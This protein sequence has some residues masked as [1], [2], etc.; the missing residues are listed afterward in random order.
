MNEITNTHLLFNKQ[1][2]LAVKGY[3]RHMN[4]VDNS[5]S[6]RIPYARLREWDFYQIVFDDRYVLQLIM[7]HVGAVASVGAGLLDTVTGD[8]Y[9]CGDRS[10]SLRFFDRP[11]SK[12]PEAPGMVHF[13][14]K[15]LHVQFETTDKYRRL[16]FTCVDKL[17]VVAE[18]T[19]LLTNVNKSKEKLIVATP[20]KNSS[21]WYLNYKETCLVANGY[22][23]I[24]DHVYN[25]S[26]GFGIMD[27]GRG[28]I[29]HRLTWVWGA[30]C[31]KVNSKQF[32]F[33]VG[34]CT[35]DVNED[36]TECAFFYDGKTYKLDGV[37]QSMADG[38]YRFADRDKKFLLEIKPLCESR[39]QL[40]SAFHGGRSMQN[41]GKC[42]GKV[43]LDDGTVLK[44]PEFIAFCEWVK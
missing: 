18:I 39:I 19:V 37:K 27:C 21:Q 13:F 36:A 5:D 40:R 32:G 16:C 20:F 35:S 9:Y 4:F 17:G 2:R 33:N 24:E 34:W 44:I 22:C 11:P 42:S 28:V 1:G 15:E 12:N 31:T 23:R 41:F 7:S 25:I 38:K 6:V 29:P 8:Y 43:T 30:G 14:S 10:T 3:A 26:D